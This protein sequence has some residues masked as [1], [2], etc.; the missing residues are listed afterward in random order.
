MWL[1]VAAVALLCLAGPAHM[2]EHNSTAPEQPRWCSAEQ[3]TC[4]LYEDD[5][6]W[7]A[8]VQQWALTGSDHTG[9]QG[10]IMALPPAQGYY[11]TD[12]VD[13]PYLSPPPPPPPAPVKQANHPSHSSQQLPPGARPYDEWQHSPPLPP[14]TGKIVNRPPNPY[15]DK[16]KPSYPAPIQNQPIPVHSQALDRV[17]ENKVAPQKQVSETDLYLLG[18]IEKLV[19]RADLFE[20]R[21]RKMEE[22]VHSLIAG[23][24][25]KLGNKAEPCPKNFTRV[26]SGCYHVSSEVANWKG[27]SYGCRRLKGNMLEIE[28][29]QERDQ[30]TSALFTDKRYKGDVP[31][32]RGPGH[33][34]YMPRMCLLVKC[35]W[36][37]KHIRAL[38]V[39]MTGSFFY[40]LIRLLSK[41][42]PNGKLTGRLAKISL[43]L[44]KSMQLSY[45]L[46][47]MS[48]NKHKS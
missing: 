34:K 26:G 4:G 30:L 44:A 40:S 42:I 47:P 35:V 22:T 16:F 29:D 8:M 3:T 25:A 20:K 32:T 28:S 13:R 45:S 7:M 18:A 37:Y 5:G 15:K 38:A 23:L 46:F 43:G 6:P 9:R 39:L 48:A 11:V 14:N 1:P 19:Y 21:L 24:D 2:K 17:D 10:R 36:L 27:A 33:T 31:N 41:R 12:R